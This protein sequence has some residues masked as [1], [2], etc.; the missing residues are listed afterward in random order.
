MTPTASTSITTSPST[1]NHMSEDNIIPFE[2]GLVDDASTTKDQALTIM[3]DAVA[4][5]ADQLSNRV[6]Q[7]IKNLAH[8]KLAVD[9]ARDVTSEDAPITEPELDAALRDLSLVRDLVESL[10]RAMME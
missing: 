5:Q 1:H 3:G 7:L 6:E 9:H 8:I 10:E 2:L 4:E